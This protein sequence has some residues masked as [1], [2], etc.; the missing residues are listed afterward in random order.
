MF[1]SS[2]VKNQNV[3]VISDDTGSFRLPIA[4]K[5][6]KIVIIISCI[7]YRTA[8]VD[9]SSLSPNN[10]YILKIN[11]Q[12]ESLETITIIAKK[13]PKRAKADYIP[14]REIVKNAL[15]KIP[16]NY[17]TNPHSYIGCYRGYQV[18]NKRYFNLNEGIMEEFDAGFQ[19]NKIFY[20]DNQAAL[21]SFK[22]NK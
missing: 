14:V 2:A 5:S 16:L 19:T 6:D 20:K 8:E 12:V 7:G 11:S 1:A 17:P 18:L 4:Y 9:V 10:L 13:D 3:G 15:V 21:Y 22:Q